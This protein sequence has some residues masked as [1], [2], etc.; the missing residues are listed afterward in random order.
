MTASASPSRRHA[1]STIRRASPVGYTSHSFAMTWPPAAGARTTRCARTGPA[2]SRGSRTCVRRERQ[3]VVANLR[4]PFVRPPEPPIDGLAF[5]A[6]HQVRGVMAP[7]CLHRDV[8]RPCRERASLRA[9]TSLSGIAEKQ[10]QRLG[11]GRRPRWGDLLADM[12]Q[13]PGHRCHVRDAVGSKQVPPEEGDLGAQDGRHPGRERV[14]IGERI[15][16][17]SVAPVM[18]GVVGGFDDEAALAPPPRVTRPVPQLATPEEIHQPAVKCATA[19]AAHR[20]AT[21]SQ[22]ADRED[23]R[24]QRHEPTRRGRSAPGPGRRRARWRGADGLPSPGLARCCRDR[25][26][27]PGPT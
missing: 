17:R 21:A 7:P 11:S 25:T 26:R 8:V 19:R 15:R 16:R 22:H 6:R 5:Q 12:R 14:E 20:S 3:D 4:E 24:G 9:A 10:A 1:P 27:R 23:V 18:P 13:H 2:R